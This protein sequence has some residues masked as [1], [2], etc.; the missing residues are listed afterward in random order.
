M[1]WG[2]NEEQPW[3]RHH[4]QYAPAWAC[5]DKAAAMQGGNAQ[6]AHDES[7]KITGKGRTKCIKKDGERRCIKGMDV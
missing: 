6:W 5:P 4:L 1:L 3:E 2:L 7:S